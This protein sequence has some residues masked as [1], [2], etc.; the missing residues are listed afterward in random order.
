MAHPTIR[1]VGNHILIRFPDDVEQIRGGLVIPDGARE[2][3]QE[4]TVIALGSGRR[5]E[6]GRVTP[7][8]LKVGDKVL[9]A[10]FG[11]ADVKIGDRS[12]IFVREDEVLAVL[13]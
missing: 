12:Y 1:P 8:E 7:F 10:K 13:T 4:A 3:P 9:V 11:G 5:E 2:K 6:S